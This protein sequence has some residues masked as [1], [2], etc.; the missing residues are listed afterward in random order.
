MTELPLTARNLRWLMAQK[1][2]NPNDLSEAIRLAGQNVPQPTLFR[3][4]TGESRDPRTSTLQPVAEYFGITV[5]QMR[6]WDFEGRGWPLKDE[7]PHAQK[8]EPG[9]SASIRALLKALLLA[10][11]EGRLSEDLMVAILKMITAAA[12]QVQPDKYQ[13]IDLSHS[14]LEGLY[15]KQA[16]VDNRDNL[17]VQQEK[18]TKSNQKMKPDEAETHQEKTK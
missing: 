14:R 18:K 2:T 3:I 7:I 8:S 17:K 9:Y 6:E 16:I 5:N 11:K 15:Q 10:E 4:L 12:P 1:N 13:D